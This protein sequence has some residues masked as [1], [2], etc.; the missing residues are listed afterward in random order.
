MY[1]ILHTTDC[2]KCRV[3]ASKLNLKNIAFE[4]NHDMST[5]IEKGF[6]SAPVLQVGDEF[7]DFSKANEWINKQ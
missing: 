1:I 7:M 5:V 4:E 2:P 6:L 3:L